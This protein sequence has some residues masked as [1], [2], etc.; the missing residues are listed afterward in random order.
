MKLTITTTR[1]AKI[2]LEATGFDIHATI[3]IKGSKEG[4]SGVKIKY[5]NRFGN[6]LEFGPAKAPVSAETVKLIKDT[7]VAY[8]DAEIK[9][10][11][12]AYNAEK[13]AFLAS[14]EGKSWLLNEKMD[15]ANSDL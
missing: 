7:L 8:N 14:P 4:F 9:K 6:Y 12:E 10:S 1:G 15:R 3:E 13:A 2:D 5:N 11:N